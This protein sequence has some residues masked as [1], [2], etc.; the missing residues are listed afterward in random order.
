MFKL[1]TVL[2]FS[3]CTL[4]WIQAGAQTPSQI[5]QAGLGYPVPSTVNSLTPVA[6]FRS[7]DSLNARFM[8]LALTNSHVTMEVVGSSV[9][10]RDILAYRF[11]GIDG[12]DHE[13]ISLSAAMINGS[14]HAREWASPE[15]AAALFEWM[16][17]EKDAT[18]LA[19]YIHES[20]EVV[21]LPISNPDSL[22]YTHQNHDMTYGG[23]ASGSGGRDGRMRRKNLQNTDEDFS[24]TGDYLNGVD[25]NRNH[26]FGFGSGSSASPTNTLYHGP[27]AGSE[28]ESQAIYA[29][30]ALLDESRIRYYV[31][32]HS[33]SQLYY[34]IEDGT[35]GRDA[36]TGEC[37]NFMSTIT[38]GV[39]GRFYSSMV[40]DLDT[41]A[42][43]ATDEYF[44]GTY[45]SM[46]YTLEIRPTS[47][48]NGFILPN[49][50]VEETREELLAALQGGLY[51]SS[52]PSAVT[53]VRI[54]NTTLEASPTSPLVYHAQLIYDELTG[55]RNFELIIDEALDNSSTYHVVVRF[56]KPM[57]LLNEGIPDF[58]PGISGSN[59]SVQFVGLTGSIPLEYITTPQDPFGNIAHF[60]TDVAL[61]ELDL[62][63]LNIESGNF[64]LKI[65]A[66]DA[67]DRSIDAN[68]QTVAD[69][70]AQGW[71]EYENENG[72]D[73]MTGGA[74]LLHSLDYI[75]TDTAVGEFWIWH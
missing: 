44:T 75:N 55:E 36:A 56:N 32:I 72:L 6:G 46:S 74:D 3:I 62:S 23:S 33:F 69:W 50:E 38:Q 15:V 11:A 47:G 9:K 17:E 22:S 59:S 64:Q 2:A 30:A 39:S 48:T 25:L 67:L 53:D 51:Y 71:L 28:P 16:A 12:I 41:Q 68:P 54:Y 20:M 70:S 61:A 37:Y 57:R 8:D 4:S 1:R 14:I 42:V 63:G 58:F 49:S 60:T 21:I 13:G 26:S 66:T 18:P 10:G 45:Q 43:G 7:F 5:T 31:D 73:G 52:G 65:E 40:S 29:A 35:S 34:V 27:S 19:K 24:T